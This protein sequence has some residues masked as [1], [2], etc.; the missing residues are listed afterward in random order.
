VIGGS[1]TNNFLN[2]YTSGLTLLALGVRLPRWKTIIIDAV[3]A[4]GLSVY[5]IFFYDFTTAFTNFLSL[6]VAW[7]APWCAIFLVDGMMRRF[8]YR[9]DD[10]LAS[11]DGR[12]WFAGGINRAGA[13]SFLVGAVAT[14][15][16]TNATKWQSPISTHLLGGADLS[17]PVGMLIAGGMYFVLQRRSPAMLPDRE[18]VAVGQT[19]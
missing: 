11:R 13:V 14:F 1:I 19:A 16:T 9:T 4:T 12:Y 3:I 7:L 18:P 17:I 8:R 6:T 2:T 15:F 5:A 10:L